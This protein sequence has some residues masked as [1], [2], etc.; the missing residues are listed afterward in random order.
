[1]IQALPGDQ[2]Q[3]LAVG[4]REPAERFPQPGVGD[5]RDC[6]VGSGLDA[7]TADPF[8]E[9]GLPAGRAL[10]VGQAVAGHPVQPRQRL[11]G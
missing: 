7:A 2:Q 4:D 8:G 5:H 6:V 9:P 11:L 10:L 1:V 3:R